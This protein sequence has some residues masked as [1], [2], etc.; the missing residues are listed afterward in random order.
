MNPSNPGIGSILNINKNIF[1]FIKTARLYL[2]FTIFFDR[3]LL[4]IINRIDIQK[5]RLIKGPAKDISILDKLLML[6]GTET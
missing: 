2:Y 5:T 1:S 6:A 3:L 4:F